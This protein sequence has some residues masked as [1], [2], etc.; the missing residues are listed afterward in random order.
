MHFVCGAR[1]SGVGLPL[2]TRI[3]FLDPIVAPTAPTRVPTVTPAQVTL[4][5]AQWTKQNPGTGTEGQAKSRTVRLV[6]PTHVPSQ[7]SLVYGVVC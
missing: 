5:D 3:Q 7:L 2:P 6:M 4:S 1:A